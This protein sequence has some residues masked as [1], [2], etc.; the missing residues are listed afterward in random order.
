MNM[1]LQM[2]GSAS[3]EGTGGKIEQ[4]SKDYVIRIFTCRLTY[5]LIPGSL[6]RTPSLSIKHLLLQRPTVLV[7]LAC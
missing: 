2:H 6:A 7:V 1:L 4:A 5:I 3:F